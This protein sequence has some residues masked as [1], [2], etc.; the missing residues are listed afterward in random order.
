M[1][2]FTPVYELMSR[3]EVIACVITNFVLGAL[4]VATMNRSK[5]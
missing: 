1:T 3:N 5:K 2:T 4:L